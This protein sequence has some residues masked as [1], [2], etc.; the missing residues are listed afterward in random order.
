MFWPGEEPLGSSGCSMGWVQLPPTSREG[1][2]GNAGGDAA[3][4]VALCPSQP[5]TLQPTAGGRTA[6]E[7]AWPPWQTVTLPFRAGTGQPGS[8][9][10]EGSGSQISLTGDGTGVAAKTP[11]ERGCHLG[12]SL[13][14]SWHI[15]AGSQE[16]QL[17]P[18]LFLAATVAKR[19]VK[20]EMC[21]LNR[22]ETQS[23]SITPA[24]WC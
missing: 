10:T 8:G 12:N 19:G 4:W 13:P 14:S 7:P 1:D 24:R 23:A 21:R 17:S 2:T 6:M 9:V 22:S 18:G 16:C 15:W 5:L 11:W 20:T 3:S